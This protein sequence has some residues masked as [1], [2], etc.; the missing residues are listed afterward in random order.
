MK[1]FA[2]AL[3]AMLALVAG[4][5]WANSFEE[6]VHY[7]VIA[8]EVSDEPEII[9]FFSLYCNACYQYQPFGE[10]LTEE[11]GDDFKK[12]HV[13]FVAPGG[14]QE[15]IVQVWAAVNRLGISEDFVRQVFRRHFSQ[16]NFVESLSEAKS[17]IAELGVDEEEFDRVYNSFAVRSQANRMRTMAENFDV[18]ATPTYIVNR[19]YQMRPQGF[20]DS[21]SN[22]F[23]DYLELARY[24][25]QK[26]S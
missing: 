23:E 14:M 18:S 20:R 21:G 12:Y 7:E 25:I 9:D 13:N 8:D 22:F 10:M 26:D 15:H 6:G 11:F 1:K 5:I 19:K 16:N 24:L 17:V 4:P 2:A 3:A